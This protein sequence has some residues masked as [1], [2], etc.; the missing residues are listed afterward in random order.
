MQ[1]CRGSYGFQLGKK[2]NNFNEELG[3]FQNMVDNINKLPIEILVVIFKELSLYDVV[4]NCMQT[5]QKWRSI[6]V[7][8]IL[9]KQL[10]TF[11]NL[12]SRLNRDLRNDGWS[13][14]CEDNELILHLWSK[15]NAR[16]LKGTNHLGNELDKKTY[17]PPIVRSTSCSF[18]SQFNLGNTK[19]RNHITTQ[20][21][22]YKMDL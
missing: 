11:A 18:W 5:C 22:A 8:F 2:A 21:E 3:H 19:F 15:Y 17:V 4:N 13:D 1:K 14:N 7:S 6:I 9:P 10:F 16:L 20:K 12:D